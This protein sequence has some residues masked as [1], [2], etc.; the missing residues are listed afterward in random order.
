MRFK[1]PSD[2]GKILRDR[3]WDDQNCGCILGYYLHACGVKPK[4]LCKDF[5]GIAKSS[6]FDLVPKWLVEVD[7]PDAYS[8]EYNGRPSKIAEKIMLIN[9][10]RDPGWENLLIELF[11]KQGDELIFESS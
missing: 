2:P 4:N 5:R 9:M 11:A 6:D 8:N 7:D 3:M 1:V 10:D